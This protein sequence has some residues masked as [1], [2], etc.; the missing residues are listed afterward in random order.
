VSA[1]V[2]AV[3]ARSAAIVSALR[4]V[5]EPGLLTPSRLP[6]WSRLTIA[7]HLRY[8]ARALARMTT[9]T[10]TGE[11][12]AYYPGGQAEQRPSTLEPEPGESPMDVVMSLAEACD[13]LDD[14]W[15]S[16]PDWTARITEPADNRDLGPLPLERLLLLR[17]TEVEVHGTDLDLGLAD[18]SDVFVSAALP[19][20]LD[21]LNHRRSNHKA[22]DDGLR[23]SWLLTATDGD[24]T[25]L[26]SVDGPQVDSRPADRTT[27]A[28]AV[29]EGTRR[30]LLALLLGREA[31]T[32]GCTRG[33]PDFAMA[34][35]RA[36]PGP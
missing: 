29:I 23:G 30:D 9:D 17:A 19:F 26:V 33:D 36:F 31:P 8:G 16:V 35:T 27:P 12:T 28:T 25:W 6:A 21:W 5:G 34:F 18:W 4:A 22:F 7:C 1:L 2:D 24:L 32:I 3:A 10:L 13:A 20:R 14:V 11:P 15:R